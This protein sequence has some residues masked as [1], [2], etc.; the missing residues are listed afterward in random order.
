[1]SK[2]LSKRPKLLIVSD[3]AVY[4]VEKEKYFAFEPVVRE[5]E[6]FS[7]L[8]SEITWIGFR[9]TDFPIPANVREI[10]GVKLKYLLLPKVGGYGIL[11]KFLLF[12]SVPVYFI[13]ILF[14]ILCNDIVHSRGPSLP[15]FLAIL[16]S[17]FYKRPKYW[18]KFAGNWFQENPPLSY[19]V[20][21]RLLL[22]IN[23]S[24]VTI[25]GKWPD[26][27]PNILSFENPCFTA[28]E[29]DFARNIVSKKQYIGK[30]TIL[31]VGRIEEEKGVGRIF[32]ALKFLKKDNIE[33]VILAGGSKEISYYK[34]KYKEI[35][36]PC[37]FTGFQNRKQLNELYAIS[38]ILLLPTLCSEGFPKVVAEAAAFGCVPVVS[39]VSSLK[40]YINNKNGVCLTDLTGYAIS[41][42]INQLMN[43]RN[44]LIQMAKELTS[45]TDLFTY[46][47]YN[48]RIKQEIL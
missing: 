29:L 45:L 11:N 17:K 30:L 9:Y 6:N 3:T 15:A 28:H 48:Q 24:I 8:F 5:I 20:Q 26:Q 41:E 47:R 2:D 19:F 18:H 31:F 10:N 46:E 4:F 38:H 7:H 14:K 23:N 37:I 12:A 39:G 32:D 40:Q 35:D 36:I 44:L 43:N 34:E 1:M 42:A 16:I 27:K 25:N 33:K 22:N 13:I 21:K